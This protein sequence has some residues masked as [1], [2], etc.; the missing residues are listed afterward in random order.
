[1]RTDIQKKYFIGTPRPGKWASVY[2]YSPQ[3]DEFIK[4]RGDI[5]AAISMTGPDSF[6]VST[7]GNL[8][9]DHLHETY[10]ENPEDKPLLALEKAV[11]ST[12]NYLQKLLEHD[13]AAETGIDIDLI[14]LVIHKRIAYFV[15][16]GQGHAHMLRDGIMVDIAPSLKDPTGRGHVRVGSTM[17]K[18]GDVIMLSSPALV[19]EMTRDELLDIAVEFNDTAFKQRSFDNGPLVSA[20]MIGFG[21]DR[22]EARA[23]R[24]LQET[25]PTVQETVAKMRE[26]KA[27]KPVVAPADDVMQDEENDQE[28]TDDEAY[29]DEQSMYEQ[30][31]FDDT[32]AQAL[33]DRLREGAVAVKTKLTNFV[34]QQRRK[35]SGRPTPAAQSAPAAEAKTT[36]TDTEINY[37]QPTYKVMLDRVAAVLKQV[38]MFLKENIW[39]GILGMKK[40]GIYLKGRGPGRN[41]RIVAFVVIVVG[42]ILFFSIRS[43]NENNARIAL[44]EEAQLRLDNAIELIEEVDKVAEII[45]GA[46]NNTERRDSMLA[47]LDEAEVE[48]AAVGDVEKFQDEVS[49]RSARISELRDLLNKVISVDDPK[50]LVDVGGLF[51]GASPSDITLSGGTL[52]IS[53]RE[54]GKV[55]QI[56][57]SGGSLTELATGLTSPRSI[58][59]DNNGDIVVL[60]ED[61]DR[62]LGTISAED[63][64]I[65]RHAGTS[66]FRLGNIRDIEFV[67]IFG[68]RVYGVDQSI[69]SVVMLQRSGDAYGIPSKRFELEELSTGTDL[70]INDLKIY[71]LA[72][73]MQ[74]LYRALNN[75]NDT[76]QLLGLDQGENLHQATAMFVDEVYVYIADPVNKRILVFVKDVET[77]PLKAQYQYKGPDDGTFANIKEIIADRSSGKLF[78]L[79][80]TA[81]FELPLAGLENF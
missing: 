40:D 78:V 52:Y 75:E 57:A 1:M 2:T 42:A 39:E 35:R 44:E 77:M 63:G 4:K 69:K 15:S 36:A 9:L 12:Q 66:E 54:Y 53:D 80:G 22:Q 30:A 56:P 73:I 18:Q 55:Y 38:G 81:V 26:T 11:I 16:M 65:V 70:S 59:A 67:D 17:L 51:P 61:G 14:A 32:E 60:D 71:V 47:K 13:D 45:A 31:T 68:G 72:D 43:I 28:Y 6:N 41:W 29:D 3:N 79:D 19:K 10:F 23:E 33:V 27:D 7:A 49:T 58:T 46:S 8:L 50:Q 64:S 25:T 5:F 24:I 20:I 62:R 37:D 76:P 21:V 74:G 48:L 34:N